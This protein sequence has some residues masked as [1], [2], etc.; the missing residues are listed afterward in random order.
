[1]LT[2]TTAGAVSSAPA[3]S[4]SPSS[5][6]VYDYGTVA[7]GGGSMQAFTLTNSGGTATGSLAIALS[8]SAAFVKTADSCSAISLGPNKSCAVSVRYAPAVASPADTG[9][10][11][12]TSKKP[13]ATATITLQGKSSAPPSV[14]T[15]ASGSHTDTYAW[16]I[17][18]SVDQTTVTQNGGTATVNYTVT[19][20]PNLVSEYVQVT[21]GIQVFNSNTDHSGG[22]VPLTLNSVNDQL[23]DGTTCTVSGGSLVLASFETDFSYVCNTGSLPTRKLYNT[24]TIAWSQQTLANGASLDP[25]TTTFTAKR[26]AFTAIEIDKCGTITDPVAPGG[27]LG[28]VCAGGSNP[29]TFTYPRT[30]AVPSSGFCTTYDNTATLTTETTGTQIQASQSVHACGA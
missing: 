17:G 19:A 24:A 20:S 5:N 14:T 2:P 11:T 10:L 16:T 27:T 21:G 7:A 4:W 18:K 12:A 9:T 26:I 22:T 29:A 23:S 30:V 6:G 8:G 28:T 13:A 1:M 25:G 3:L 15:D